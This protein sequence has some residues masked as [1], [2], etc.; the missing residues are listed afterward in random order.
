MA[1]FV[2]LKHPAT[3]LVM[4]LTT[5]DNMTNDL[6]FF[7]SLTTNKSLAKQMMQLGRKY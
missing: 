7:K 3:I 6:L 1:T 5:P 2:A 4:V